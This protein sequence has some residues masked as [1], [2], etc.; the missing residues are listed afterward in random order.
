MGAVPSRT[1]FAAVLGLLA[2]TFIGYEAFP[3][4]DDWA[5]APLTEHRADPSLFPRDN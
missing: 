3:F 1:I 4:G 5:Y 2:H